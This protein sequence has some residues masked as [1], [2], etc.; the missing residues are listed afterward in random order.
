[1]TTN[2]Q[3]LGCHSWNAL[4]GGRQDDNQ[5]RMVVGIADNRREARSATSSMTMKLIGKDYCVG[6]GSRCGSLPQPGRAGGRR[7]SVIR[8][9]SKPT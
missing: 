2:I 8:L 9:P 4:D 3:R 1:M 5:Q 6:P 7:L